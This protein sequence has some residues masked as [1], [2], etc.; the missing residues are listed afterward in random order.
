MIGALCSTRRFAQTCSASRIMRSMLCGLT[1]L[2]TPALAWAEWTKVTRSS[3]GTYYL[4]LQ[5]VRD[6]PAGR[7]AFQ[8]LDLYTPDR[9]GYLSYTFLYE[10]ECTRGRYRFMRSEYF[11]GRM[12]EGV[13]YSGSEPSTYFLTPK[14]TTVDA[15]IMRRVCA[16]MLN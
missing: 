15:R 4:D 9:D 3:R 10:Y 6:T 2:L 8:L 7:M 5:S 16:A 14:A 13:G 12:G 11:P 1:F